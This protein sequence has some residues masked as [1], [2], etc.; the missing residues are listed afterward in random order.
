[1]EDNNNEEKK[2][3]VD[4]KGKNV[5]Y[6]ARTMIAAATA[7]ALGWN[8]GETNIS[9]TTDW[10]KA[11]EVRAKTAEKNQARFSMY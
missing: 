1:M 3:K 6:Q 11:K 5:S 10:R 2:K 9:K 7:N 4:T 8:I